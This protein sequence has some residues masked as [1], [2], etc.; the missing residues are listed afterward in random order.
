M[1]G[2]L[3]R[4]SFDYQSPAKASKIYYGVSMNQDDAND[5]TFFLNDEIE[6]VV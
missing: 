1:A 4:S 3:P 5:A 2:V 6:L